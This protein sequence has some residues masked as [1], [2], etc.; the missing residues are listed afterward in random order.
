[1]CILSG[2]GGWQV[3]GVDVEKKRCQD[4]SLWEAVLEVSQPA[5]FVV[6]GGKGEAAIANHFHDQPD[7]VS[8]R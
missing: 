4:G 7:P 2:D 6:T 8:V 3:R 5:P 1:V